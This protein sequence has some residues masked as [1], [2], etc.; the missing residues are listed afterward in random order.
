MGVSN[1]SHCMRISSFP[2][3]AIEH[4][5]KKLSNR[6]LQRDTRATRLLKT[7]TFMMQGP[8]HVSRG[9][10][11]EGQ[12]KPNVDRQ[13]RQDEKCVNSADVDGS[14]STRRIDLP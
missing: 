7:V 13:E 4:G 3:T 14:F 9:T 11:Q 10:R 8:Q 12:M 2:S 5:P 1:S 6:V